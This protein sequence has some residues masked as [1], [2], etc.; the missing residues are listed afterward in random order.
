[1]GFDQAA[2]NT[3]FDRVVSH[4][5]GLGIFQSINS[6]E[7]KS[8]PTTGG[9]R[10][11]F[12]VQ[13]IRSVG[14]AS[15]LSATSGVVTLNGR[16]YSSALQQPADAIDPDML[17]A[18]TTLLGAYTGDFDLGGTVRCI[19]LLGMYGAPLSATAGYITQD[20]VIERIMTIVLPIVVN[21]LWVQVS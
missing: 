21:D 16:I 9:L 14:Q 19:D 5:M 12:W 6:H 4:A 18:A 13:D 11:A 17:T 8:R 20:R 3:L 10:C 15:G 1:M 7:P 2:V